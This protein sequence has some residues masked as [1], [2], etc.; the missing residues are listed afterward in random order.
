V[1]AIA[2]AAVLLILAVPALSLEFGDGAL[3]Q[4]PE[5]NET[6][7]GA[8]LAAR[9]LGAGASGPTQIVAG[10]TRAARPTAPRPRCGGRGGAEAL[11]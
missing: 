5:G 3:R 9:E 10:P 8:G 4:F 2:S 1:S 6:R 7:V 11:A